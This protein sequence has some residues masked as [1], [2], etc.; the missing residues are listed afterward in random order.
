MDKDAQS[1]G[2]LIDAC[3]NFLATYAPKR[4]QVESSFDI[5]ASKH[6]DGVTRL[7]SSELKNQLVLCSLWKFSVATNY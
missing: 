3:A 1:V 4:E 6:V 5:T 2:T 7:L